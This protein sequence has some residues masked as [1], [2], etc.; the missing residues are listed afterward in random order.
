MSYFVIK[1]PRDGSQYLCSMSK[2]ECPQWWHVRAEATKFPDEAS[3]WRYLELVQDKFQGSGSYVGRVVRVNTPA[4]RRAELERLRAE[5]AQH[6]GTLA[7][8]RALHAM[9]LEKRAEEPCND[10][11]EKP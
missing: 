1:G 5:V 2:H 9:E 11:D 7:S 6:R 3:A 10:K 4:D 8:I